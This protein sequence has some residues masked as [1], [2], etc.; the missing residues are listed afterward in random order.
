MGPSHPRDSSL[1]HA[2]VLSPYNLPGACCCCCC[3]IAS[4]ITIILMHTSAYQ[5]TIIGIWMS[6]YDLLGV[7]FMM[8]LNLS[9]FYRLCVYVDQIYCKTVNVSIKDLVSLV[10]VF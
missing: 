5:Q 2:P 1:S 4:A 6:V 7:I 10:V 9:S 3:S 8:C